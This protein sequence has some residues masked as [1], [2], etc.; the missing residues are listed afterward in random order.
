MF[1][2]LYS[3]VVVAQAQSVELLGWILFEHRDKTFTPDVLEITLVQDQLL[4]SHELDS[5]ELDHS[6]DI[7]NLPGTIQ[8]L[9]VGI[10]LD[11]RVRG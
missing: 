3:N 9:R 1:D 2:P 8:R 11:V 4:H 5:T 7:K 6:I 10:I